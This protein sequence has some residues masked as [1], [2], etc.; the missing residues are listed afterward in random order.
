MFL[1]VCAWE[2]LGVG[3]INIGTYVLVLF[4]Y[5]FWCSYCVRVAVFSSLFVTL[6]LAIV[7]GVS[8]LCGC[9]TASSYSLYTCNYGSRGISYV[10]ALSVLSFSAVLGCWVCVGVVGLLHC[11]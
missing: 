3:K 6:L 11:C 10:V 5:P 9:A 4:L 8:V 7:R 1:S 2:W